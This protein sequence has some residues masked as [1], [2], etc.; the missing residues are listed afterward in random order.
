MRNI[1][2]LDH[3]QSSVTGG[4]KY[5]DAFEA[6]L[7]LILGSK[8]QATPAC[9]QK[10]KGWKKIFS[11]FVELK[12]L[13][14]F[15]KD[16][17]VMF[18][19]TTYRHHFLLALLNKWITMSKST[20]I[21]HHF[22]FIGKEGLSWKFYKW[23]MCKYI[24]LMDSII[25]PS[26]FTLD[27]AKSLFPNKKI[28]YV[29]L[30][31]ERNFK[32]SSNYEIGNLLYVGTIEERKGLTFLIDSISMLENKT[33]VKLN[34]V[35]KVVDQLYYDNLKHQ[36]STA[37]LTDNVNFLGRV[38]DEILAEYYQ[39][40]EIF[41]FPSLLEGYGIVLIEA[42]NNGLPIICF[43][44]TAMPYTV[45]DG[46]NG[47]VAKNKDAKD[48]ASKIQLLMGNAPLR[49]KLQEGIEDTVMNLKT[50]EDFQKAIDSFYRY[51]NNE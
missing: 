21:V 45:K 41:T 33:S 35:G 29:P 13:R 4:H 6:H 25:V 51:V 38:S 27:V 3:H 14:L 23:L 24:S 20:M 10:Y 47:F 1:I 36:I 22:S 50:Q 17:L 15:R 16:T 26:P 28:F 42:F 40:A 7:E 32:K 48:M 39:K 9:A 37:G 49:E 43:D 2:Y 46:V 11:P 30:P 31:F 44:N 12:Y 19:D 18:G 8:L 34:I 5:N